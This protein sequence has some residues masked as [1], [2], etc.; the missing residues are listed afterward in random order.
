MKLSRHPHNHSP[1]STSPIMA[2]RRFGGEGRHLSNI[3]KPQLRIFGD[4][5]MIR[6]SLPVP[7]NTLIHQ[8]NRRVNEYSSTCPSAEAQNMA[9]ECPQVQ[10]SSSLHSKYSQSQ[11]LGH[12]STTG[13]VVQ[14]I[15]QL[16]WYAILENNI[17]SK[18]LHRRPHAG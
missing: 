16:S 2:G 11:R 3:G 4:L 9:T 8:L 10:N 5:N 12:F 14:L 17:S 15:Q 6:P 18:L 1:R 13:T 7:F